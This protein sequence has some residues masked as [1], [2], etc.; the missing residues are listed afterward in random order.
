VPCANG[1]NQRFDWFK[2]KTSIHE[3][4]FEDYS[5]SVLNEYLDQKLIS[6]VRRHAK[7]SDSLA[8][9]IFAI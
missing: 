1:P 7:Q 5:E 8:I 9:E 2:S 6:W 4:L 3:R